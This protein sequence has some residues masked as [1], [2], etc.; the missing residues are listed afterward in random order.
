[1]VHNSSPQTGV[2]PSTDPA[3]E[4]THEHTHTHLHHGASALKH[5]TPEEDVVYSSGTT[6]EPHTIPHQD[7]MDDIDHRRQTGNAQ[8]QNDMEKGAAAYNINKDAVGYEV[9]HSASEEEDPKHHGFSGF[10]RK[11]RIFFHL[12]LAFVIT[13]WWIASLVLHAVSTRISFV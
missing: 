13:G 12:G 4:T 10:Y 2:V 6:D 9:E 5:R 1:M 11:H 7:K 3:L 8:A